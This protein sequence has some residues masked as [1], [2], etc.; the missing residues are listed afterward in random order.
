MRSVQA[1]LSTPP[2]PF[3]KV[4][5]SILRPAHSGEYMG[6]HRVDLEFTFAATRC[7]CHPQGWPRGG[8]GF[9]AGGRAPGPVS[10]CSGPSPANTGWR[11]PGVALAVAP[12]PFPPGGPSPRPACTA[13][14]RKRASWS[15][16]GARTL[17]SCGP[18]GTERLS[19]SGHQGFFSGPLCPEW[20]PS[21][22]S[23]DG[24]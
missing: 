1:L 8:D 10:G 16:A 18:H 19:R 15:R 3:W 9:P 17:R 13:A 14:Q 7:V 21:L 23:L 6:Q 5:Q 11:C 4:L 12:E 22:R 24:L 20:P 2:L